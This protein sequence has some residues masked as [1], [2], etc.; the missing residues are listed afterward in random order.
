Y[1]QPRLSPQIDVERSLAAMGYIDRNHLRA[2]ALARRK[3][4]RL[5]AELEH[6]EHWLDHL[7]TSSD[8]VAGFLAR[9]QT[10]GSLTER[11]RQA[12]RSLVQE[13]EPAM[14]V[15]SLAFTE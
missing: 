13:L 15:E 8:T 10:F 14:P 4:S 2:S 7:E 1:Y 3:N 9:F 12:W 5:S 11:D 6:F